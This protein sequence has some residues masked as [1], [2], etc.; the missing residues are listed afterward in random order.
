MRV[1]RARRNIGLAFI[2]LATLLSL[3]VEPAWA[4]RTAGSI[5]RSTD[6]ASAPTDSPDKPSPEP[7]PE[8]SP[9]PEPS[10]SPSPE[11][12]PEPSPSPTTEPSPAPSPTTTPPPKGDPPPPPTGGGST[13][14]PGSGT[15]TSSGTTT[16]GVVAGTTSTALLPKLQ[17]RAIPAPDPV[18]KKK[19]K[20]TEIEGVDADALRGSQAWMQAITSRITDLAWLGSDGSVLGAACRGAA[21]GTRSAAVLFV[22]LLI[23]GMVATLAWRFVTSRARREPFDGR[24]ADAN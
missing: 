7:S 9:T 5:A 13:S 18:K 14:P 17:D 3:T 6:I 23:T 8:P 22:L 4:V 11:P 12:S 15:G 21:C 2:C 20:A 10:P 19:P 24:S 16:V 1:N